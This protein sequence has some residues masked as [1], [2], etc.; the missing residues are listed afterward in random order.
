L[1]EKTGIPRVREA[2]EA[3]NWHQVDGFDEGCDFGDLGGSDFGEFEVGKLAE[4][5]EESKTKL[6]QATGDDDEDEED[7]D[8]ENLD[9]GFDKEDFAGMRKA[10]WS[11]SRGTGEDGVDDDEANDED[12]QKLEKMMMKLQ[13]V[14]DMSAGLPEDQ[15]KRMAK[16]A[17]GEVMKDL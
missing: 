3:N 6:G 10:I 15:R 16:Q 9:F 7:F 14:R 2:L 5:T 17:V 12:V 1:V 8:P 11:S 13:A 4:G